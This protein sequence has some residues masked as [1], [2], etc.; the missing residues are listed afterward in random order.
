MHRLNTPSYRDRVPKL[1]GS[2]YQATGTGFP[3]YQA[4][5]IKLQAQGCKS[6][7]LKLSNYQAQ[8]IKLYR[9]R[10]AKLLGSSYQTTRLRLPGYPGSGYQATR[11][12]LPFCGMH[13]LSTW[14]RQ[15]VSYEQFN[16]STQTAPDRA[17][18]SPLPG[19]WL[20]SCRRRLWR[21][22]S[23]LTRRI[24]STQ[25]HLSTPII[26]LSPPQ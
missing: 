17:P 19:G 22:T 12:R 8:A 26:T 13:R 1:P 11:L 14:Q 23:R 25:P 16:N 7:R 9:H 15:L 20:P 18:D 3:S 21:M 5:A 24:T 10:V 4:Q 6:H 2:G